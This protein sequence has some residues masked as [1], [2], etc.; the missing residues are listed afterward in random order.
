MEFRLRCLCPPDRQTNSPQCQTA[1][2]SDRP[3]QPTLANRRLHLIAAGHA[4][5]LL[6]WLATSLGGVFGAWLVLPSRL[7]MHFDLTGAADAWASAPDGRI[8][9]WLLPPL[10]GLA[11]AAGMHVF[12]RYSRGRPHLWNCPGG[13]PVDELSP[14]SQ[15]VAVAWLQ[16]SL[17]W[18]AFCV[19]LALGVLHAGWLVA[20][21]QSTGR[22]PVQV[23]PA[24]TAVLLLVVAGM[25]T[26]IVG[27]QRARRADEAA[28]SASRDSSMPGSGRPGN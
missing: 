26:C 8:V 21:A 9:I 6:I 3:F 10:I 17:G 20:G 7:P 27:V 25:V 13:V 28:S 1:G 24:M 22:M 4:F 11:I 18:S 14:D 5:M 15:A 23:W 12:L 2:H 16:L 19:S